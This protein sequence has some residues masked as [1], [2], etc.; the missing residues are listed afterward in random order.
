[1]KLNIE[2][3]Q[4]SFP[5]NI[6]LNFPSIDTVQNISKTMIFTNTTAC[7]NAKI[8]DLC[9][10]VFLDWIENN[11]CLTKNQV[12]ILQT[13]DIA[14]IWD[15]IT[16]SNITLGQT[17]IILIPTEI[18]DTEELIVPQEWID[19]PDLVG[20][21]YLPMQVD[22]DNQ[23]VR[24]WGYASHEILKNKGKYD[25]IYRTYSL[26][27]EHIIEDIETLWLAIEMGLQEI[28]N[29]P[30]ITDLSIAEAEQ[31]LD[32]LSKPSPYSP[33][34]ELS[35]EQWSA[36]FG[37][38]RL[39]QELYQKRLA[40]AT[41]TNSLGAISNNKIN[42]TNIEEQ[43]PIQ[44]KL[45]DL[46]QWL[47]NKFTKSIELGWH[48]IDNF[49]FNTETNLAYRNN[50]SSG[51]NRDNTIQRGKLIKLQMQVDSVEVILLVG[52]TPQAEDRVKVVIQL[53]PNSKRKFLP[54]GLT[55]SLFSEGNSI[56]QPIVSQED[57]IYLQSLP[58]D[59]SRNTDFKV[60]ISLGKA[61]LIEEFTIT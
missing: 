8:N 28:A 21:Y 58:L 55:M 40:W 59:C 1:M 47:D 9:L 35:F 54:S 15:A 4:S 37:N 31:F 34:L 33:R 10:T 14:S 5:E 57:D 32:K 3:L 23:L 61:F 45:I 60:K 6:W 16:G 52:V 20:N 13:E 38:S 29:I 25:P 36:L 48:S 24:I 53:H 44:T 56:C 22:S 41:D 18:I 43:K 2:Q 26:A 19:I 17:K 42:S 12:K 11:L 30:N 49:L 7:N 27:R 39:R 46:T 51:G 50:L